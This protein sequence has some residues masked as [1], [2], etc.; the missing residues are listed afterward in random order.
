MNYIGMTVTGNQSPAEDNVYRDLCHHRVVK[1]CDLD[2]ALVNMPILRRSDDGM[3]AKK[4]HTV[5]QFSNERVTVC[6][7]VCESAVLLRVFDRDDSELMQAAEA[8]DYLDITLGDNA[9]IMRRHSWVTDMLLGSSPDDG[10]IILSVDK[11][12]NNDDTCTVLCERRNGHYY[13]AECDCEPNKRR[14]DMAL[15]SDKI[16]SIAGTK[17][18]EAVL[19]LDG[20]QVAAI[21]PGFPEFDKFKKEFMDGITAISEPTSKAKTKLSNLGINVFDENQNND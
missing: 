18:R 4:T 3:S 13:V 20:I 2:Q 1:L 10:S 12:D 15:V 21:N 6:Q 9:D 11:A 5:T 16:G 7:V 14:N 8:F 17:L 19:S